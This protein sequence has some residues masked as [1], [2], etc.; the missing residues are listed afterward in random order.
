VAEHELFDGDDVDVGEAAPDDNEMDVDEVAVMQAAMAD[1]E[2][3]R[4]GVGA[5]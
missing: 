4:S 1:P 2:S 3:P 5:S